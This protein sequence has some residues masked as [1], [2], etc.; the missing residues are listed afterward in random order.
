MQNLA[1]SVVLLISV[2]A[3]SCAPATFSETLLRLKRQSGYYPSYQ[4][5]YCPGNVQPLGQCNTASQCTTGCSCVSQPTTQTGYCCPGAS[6][7]YTGYGAQ[8][9]Y[10]GYGQTGYT[11]QTYGQTAYNYPQTGYASTQYNPQTGYGSTQYQTGYGSTQYNP[12]ASTSYYTG[13][14]NYGLPYTGQVYPQ[15]GYS[16]SQPYQQT[17][18]TGSQYYPQSGYSSSQ[19]YPQTGTSGQYGYGT[20]QYYPQTGMTGTGYGDCPNNTPAYMAP[21]TYTPQTCQLGAQQTYLGTG[22]PAN[23]ACVYASTRMS[24]VCCMASTQ[25]YGQYGSGS[26]S[27]FGKKK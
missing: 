24:Y 11:G 2:T 22:C 18:Y 17:G 7:A 15:T 10:T 26:I 12:S 16:S 20:S 13:A 9:A 5:S 21:G 14:Q 23:Y 1:L 6:T 8:Q 19:Y 25:Q 3:V 4:T 27:P